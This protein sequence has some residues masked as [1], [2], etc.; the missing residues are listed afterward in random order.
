MMIAIDRYVP[1]W[2]NLRIHESSPGARGLS[3]AIQDEAK[4]YIPTQYFPGIESGQ[5]HQGIR[6]ENIEQ[7]S[8]ADA[9]FDLVITQDVMEHVFHPDQ[10]YREISR[11]L[12]QGGYHI[13]T[14]PIY[15]SMVKSERRAELRDGE[16]VHLA[17]PEYHG[18]PVGD[19]RALVTFRY[20]YDLPELIAS[21]S[22]FAVELWR[23]HDKTNGLVAEFLEVLI[24]RKI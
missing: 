19:G 17:E 2:R 10:A 6:C 22:P 23:P 11:T 21:W 24:C 1:D 20:G 8:F 7:Q 16:I 12:K 3:L 18:N 5:F 15:K 14:T 13:H 4:H 9:S